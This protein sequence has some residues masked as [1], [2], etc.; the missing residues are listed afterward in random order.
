MK[1][2]INK[3]LAAR[4]YLVSDGNQDVNQAYYNAFLLSNYG[5]IVDRPNLVTGEMVKTIDDIFHL[6]VP[7]SFYNNPQDMRYFTKAELLI[8]Q[9]VSYFLVETGTGIYDRVEIFEKDLPEYKVGNE[10]KLRS[11]KI[12]TEEESKAV[13][14]D[15][16]NAFCAYTRPFSVEERSEF[17]L[18]FD[19]GYYVDQTIKCR[20]NIFDLVSTDIKFA[21]MLD[22]KD[23]VKLSVATFGDRKVFK[24][25]DR[26]KLVLISRM[27]PL[28][29]TCPMSKKQ[30]KYFNKLVKVCRSEVKTE[31][32]ARSPY[33]AAMAKVNAGDVVG[34]AKVFAKNGALLERNLKF[35]LSRANPVE[36]C[37]ILGLLNFKNPIVLYQ[38]V[39]SMSEDSSKARTFK[40]YKNNK[41]KSHVETD[42]ETRWRKSRLNESTCKFLHDASLQA[43]FNYYKATPSLGKIYLD[44]AFYKLAVPMNTTAST[45]GIDTLP[46]GSRMRI[47]SDKVR[48]FVH[49]KKAFDIDAS[50]TAYKANGDSRNMYFG[51]YSSKPFGN[52]VLF[53][54]D[55][56]S[57]SG[58]EF[59][60]IDLDA[61]RAQ[62]FTKI[63]YAINGYGD[64]FNSGE[65]FCGYQVKEDF[66]TRAW[67]A[68]NI[69]MQ[70]QVKS[71]SRAMAVFGIDLASNELVVLNTVFESDSR[72]ISEDEVKTILGYF[73]PAYLEVSM[74]KIIENIGELV[75][76]PEEADV[77]FS[78]I[79]MPL[80]NQ[81]VIR[82]YDL[83][84]LVAIVNRS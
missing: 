33:K 42:Y 9:L 53:S 14:M 80:E 66:R 43:I 35:L 32:N 7:K 39:L 72:V 59:F 55:D 76:T 49:W 11:V 62:G 16:F 2:S 47:A 51:N 19:N 26:E 15:I 73:E 50:I 56:R 13:L 28:V 78:D 8:E 54:G 31:T 79:C 24:A 84:Q 63:V 70:M 48:T 1:T 20:D 44:D 10:I 46:T 57:S 21:R 34:A 40:F 64:N 18:L 3:I 37:E 65:I 27:I 67:D 4:H 75:A 60:D 81:K 36:A 30:A 12:V 58:A 38:L 45:K 25:D 74:G 5:I 6:D 23:V 77:I 71:D 17:A 83:E 29:R 52:A 82:T 69:E 61:M 41:M 68:K 22:R